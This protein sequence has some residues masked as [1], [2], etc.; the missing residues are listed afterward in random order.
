VRILLDTHIFLWLQTEPERLG[1]HL[2]LVEDQRN[3]LLLSA[4]SSWEIAIKYAIGRLPLP[5]SPE[6]YVPDRMRAIG[7]RGLPVEHSHALAVAALPPLHGD[8]FDRLLVAQAGL[9]DVPILSADTTV[10]A[11][12]VRTIVVD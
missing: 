9:L 11:Y 1:R 6:R 10:A 2:P 5:E 7:A 8:P 3:E 12:P 4:A